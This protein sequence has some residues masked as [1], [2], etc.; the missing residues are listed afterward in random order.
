ILLT[1]RYK[2]KPVDKVIAELE[3]IQRIWPRPFIEFADDN[4]F[5]HREHY[6]ALLRRMLPMRLRWVTETD[7]RVAEDDELVGLMRDSG[8][9]QVVIGL[10]SPRRA[11]LDGVELKSNW[12]ACQQEAY[13]AAIGKIQSYGIT[14]NGCFILGLDGDTPAVF[15]DVLQFVR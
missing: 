9:Q 6:K 4:S 15:E 11:S 5:V 7:V 1:S 10:E 8:C 14:V 3:E 2:L 12:K 13:R